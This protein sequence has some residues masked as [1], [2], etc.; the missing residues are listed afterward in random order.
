MLHYTCMLCANLHHR[1]G[2]CSVALTALCLRLCARICSFIS[3]T[4]LLN[5]EPFLKASVLCTLARNIL[6]SLFWL[7]PSL[8]W[9]PGSQAAVRELEWVREVFDGCVFSA[10]HF[11]SPLSVRYTRTHTRTH[12]MDRERRI[13]RARVNFTLKCHGIGFCWT[14]CARMPWNGVP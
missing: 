4:V 3:F 9:Q 1:T 12:T 11:F 14:Q 6:F 2:F 13:S 7:F 10:S 8:I 5:Y